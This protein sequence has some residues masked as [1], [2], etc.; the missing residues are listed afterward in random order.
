VESFA[1]ALL[2]RLRPEHLRLTDPAVVARDVAD[3]VEF[4][5]ARPPDGPAVRVFTPERA[6]D[7]ASRAATVVE[8]DADEGAHVVASVAEEIRAQGHGVARSLHLTLGTVRTADGR[9]AEVVPARHAH[10]RE[11]FVQVELDRVLAPDEQ[12]RLAAGVR[13]T[14]EAVAVVRR[15][16][17]AMRAAVED[18]A[19][20]AAGGE[21]ADFLRWLLD[22]HFVLMGTRRYVIVTDATGAPAVQVKGGLGILAVDETSRY[23]RPVPVDELPP[24]L[25][26]RVEGGELLSITKTRRPA[27]VLERV[28][29]DDVSV[30]EVSSDGRVVGELRILGVFSA[31]ADTEPSSTTPVLR[32]R[33]ARIL[34]LEDVVPG[35][36]DEAA[37]TAL[38]Q[39]IPKDELFTTSLPE[40]RRTLGE[41]R[42]AEDRLEVRALFRRDVAAGALSVILAVP[43]ERYSSALRQR[44][45]DHLRQ[46]FGAASVAADISLGDRAEAVVRFR[47]AGVTSQ[48]PLATVHDEVVGL[49]RT[50][51]DEVAALLTDRHGLGPARDL[52]RAIV[53]RLPG[54][55]RLLAPPE[56]AIEDVE[57][58]AAVLADARSAGAAEGRAVAL[59]QDGDGTWVVL[60]EVGSSLDLSTVVPVIESLGLVVEQEHSFS[61][62]EHDHDPPAWID[63][64]RVRT[65]PGAP[66]LDLADDGPRLADAVRAAL[67]GRSEVDGMNRLVTRAALAWD[68]VAI[69]RAYRQYRAQA[70][71]PYTASTVNEALVANPA[72]A[73][74]LVELFALRFGP[75]RASTPAARVDEARASVYSAC[76]AVER[77]DHDRVLRGFVGLLDATVRTNRYAPAGPPAGALALKLGSADV[78]QLPRPV[79]YREIFVSAPDL[80]GVHLRAGPVARGGI[81]WSDRVD[82]YRTEILDLMQAQVRKNAVIV[83]TGA[84]GGFV[85]RR[86]PAGGDE[87][88][89]EVRRCYE[90]FIRALLSVTDDVRGD[91]VE[92]P[93][94]VRRHDGDDPYLVVAA[95]R[96]TATFSDLANT[97]AAE[98]GFWLGD[99]F[100]SG[101]SHGYDHKELGITARGAWIAVQRHFRELD[102]DVQTDP[103]T[104]VGIGDMS[105][106]VFGN[107]LL[108]SRAVRLVAA[109]DHRHV[110]VDPDPTDTEAAW[111]ERRRL[112]EK[113]GS[114]WDDY[115]RARLSPG[116]G[117]WPRSAKH[118]PIGPEVR[119]R[120][121]LADDVA[122]LT[123][124]ELIRAVLQAPVDLLLAGGIGTFVKASDED[125]DDIGDR[126]NDELRITAEQVRARVVGEGANL[127]LT[128]RA[129][130]QYAR[131]GGHVN[132]D[133]IDNSAGVD[134]SDHEVNAKILL[135]LAEEHGRLGS[136]AG[137][138]AAERDRL[139]QEATDDIVADVLRNNFLQSRRLGFEA[140]AS[141]TDLAAYAEV[142]ARMEVDGLVDAAVDD[143][144]DA[145]ELATRETAGAGLT[146]PEL[147]VLLSAAKRGLT[148]A[149]LRD[150]AIDDPVLDPVLAAY[151]PRAWVDRFGPELLRRHRLRRELVATMVAKE[152]VDRM[153]IPWALARAADHVVA[154]SAA[155]MAWWIASEIAG[156]RECWAEIDRLD[157]ALRPEEVAEM[158]AA[159]ADVVDAVA[160]RLLA[161]GEAALADPAGLLA[162]DRAAARRLDAALDALGPEGR[163]RARARRAERLVDADVPAPLAARIARL[164]DLAVALEGAPVA[165]DLGHDVTEVAVRQFEVRER[166]GLDAVAELLDR[167]PGRDHWTRAAVAGA[168]ADLRQLA[169]VGVRRSLAGA[170][171]DRA[172]VGRA[173]DLVRQVEAETPTVAS[174]SVA[175]RALRTVLGG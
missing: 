85:L 56:R 109:F 99:A 110:F 69:L 76:D 175:I 58:L 14:L 5:D 128:P 35:S 33:L 119:R 20:E 42:A 63:E 131:R 171:P 59:R 96:G 79:P 156:A 18:A 122:S 129:R 123:P 8:V 144:P 29:M 2:P 12:E 25:R 52:V 114:S 105:G 157:A 23:A 30:T 152:C 90:R 160:D 31:R 108:Q 124:A 64:F 77:L 147:S 67:D 68:D 167:V 37:L 137:E 45:Q 139:L 112:F 100:A 127:A 169:A 154:L 39:A 60:H 173:R 73:R 133:A 43:R 53:D 118:V 22:D 78:P 54:G 94:G 102:V 165:E 164:G 162:R 75:E 11:L 116:G 117:V 107:A 136:T 36:D 80:E 17:D 28:P 10:H 146:R 113:P 161:D 49:S 47:V 16:T 21:T 46:R 153:G 6:L 151:F 150:P 163:R 121:R 55:Y 115:D 140:R 62:T 9:L 24:H 50:W 111:Q 155:G 130:I 125:D 84:K 74:R 93:P 13:A 15:D 48:P 97:L 138:V 145:A 101:G 34:D 106:D 70:G 87:L 81:R 92:P 91:R 141:A 32:R 142:L 40:L 4:I 65:E 149:L 41:L 57:A 148:A 38:F 51:D 1:T 126:A 158:L 83:P 170:L 135:R 66:A 103:V 82:D 19:A 71:T 134:T 72:I 120:L 27:P 168:R 86:R 172:T 104:V 95:D 132:A 98:R 61:L 143:L 174:V 7:G 159:V 89:A 88:R 26:A 3:A 166:L 44:V